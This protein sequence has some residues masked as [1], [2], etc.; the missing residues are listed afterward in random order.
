MDFG[1]VERLTARLL[2]LGTGGGNAVLGALGDQ[3]PLE[4]AM[5]PNTWKMSSPA[6]D[7]VSI[8][9]NG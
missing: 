3:P 1:H 9:G 8:N 4:W 6:A 7:N 5:A 2:A